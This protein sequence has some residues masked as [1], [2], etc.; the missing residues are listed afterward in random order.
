MARTHTKVLNVCS[1]F[2]I[3]KLECCQQRL[4]FADKLDME[5]LKAALC[6]LKAVVN[7][8]L[9]CEIPTFVCCYWA[10]CIQ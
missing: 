1:T 2:D 10:L 4:D 6:Q 5:E 7:P 3:S 8:G 9:I